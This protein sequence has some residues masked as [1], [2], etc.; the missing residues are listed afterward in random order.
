[1]IGEEKLA[2]YVGGLGYCLGL[3]FLDI[4]DADLSFALSYCESGIWLCCGFSR[5]RDFYGKENDA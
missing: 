2:E 1:M 5:Y 3:V 4:S